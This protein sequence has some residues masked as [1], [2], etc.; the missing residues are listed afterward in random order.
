[1]TDHVDPRI[2]A[3]AKAFRAEF[4]TLNN[5]IE[6]YRRQMGRWLAAA[7]KAATIPTMEELRDF[8]GSGRTT[9][10]PTLETRIAEVLAQHVAKRPW[11]DSGVMKCSCGERFVAECD[12]QQ[13]ALHQAHVA[14]AL[15][16]VV[17]SSNASAWHEGFNDGK[18]QDAE[19]EDGPQFT[20]PYRSNDE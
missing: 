3:A 12:Y 16:P 13:R 1:M 10:T 6:A 11:S 4:P 8:L 2:E 18:R 14:A 20:N 7:D 19:G 9:P 5:G 17:T 15:A